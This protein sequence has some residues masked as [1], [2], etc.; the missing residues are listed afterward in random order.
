MI[1]QGD[2]FDFGYTQLK[3]VL[4]LANLLKPVKD[5]VKKTTN[6][7]DLKVVVYFSS[8]DSVPEKNHIS[9]ASRHAR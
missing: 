8:P 7:I 5:L 3:T 1:G 6:V 9:S 2:N 4:F